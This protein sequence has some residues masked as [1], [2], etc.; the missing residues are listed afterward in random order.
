MNFKYQ[1][2]F[3]LSEL[4]KKKNCLQVGKCVWGEVGAGGGLP[5]EE[6]KTAEHPRRSDSSL[7][8][9]LIE[10]YLTYFPL[11]DNRKRSLSRTGPISLE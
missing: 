2:K 11:I 5:R 8:I 7:F 4:K 6:K 9:L 3:T 1:S 10:H